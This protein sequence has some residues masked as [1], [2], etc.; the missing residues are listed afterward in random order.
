[1]ANYELIIIGAGLSGLAAGIRAAR[2]GVQT[3]IVE[4]HHSQSGLNSYYRRQGHLFETGLHAM[5]NF[6]PAKDKRAPLNLLFRQLHLSR[7]DFPVRE[8]IGSEIIF[9]AGSLSF[10]NDPA[11]LDVEIARLF[12]QASEAFRRLRK[13]IAN[14]DPL[15]PAPWRSARHFIQD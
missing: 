14:Y 4:Q 13:A 1:M 12:P 3:L 10:S 11:L 5:T 6:A 8:Q 15:A 7:R 9:P 2:F